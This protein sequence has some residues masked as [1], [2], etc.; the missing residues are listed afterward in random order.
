MA[1]VKRI[2]N[3]SDV[4]KIN[5]CIPQEKVQFY[6]Y[7]HLVVCF[8]FYHYYSYIQYNYYYGNYSFFYV[9]NNLLLAVQKVF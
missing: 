9:Y 3:V 4:L 5:Y 7:I 2:F 1:N 6:K 8:Y